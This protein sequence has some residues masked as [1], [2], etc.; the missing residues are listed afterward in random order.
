MDSGTVEGWILAT[1][2]MYQSEGTNSRLAHV[3]WRGTLAWTT[4][5]DLDLGVASLR[6]ALD[7]AGVGITPWCDSGCHTEP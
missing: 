4:V 1:D 6:G 7:G 5:S 3:P 2:L